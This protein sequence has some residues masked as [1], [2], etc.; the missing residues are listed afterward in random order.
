M[1]P[2]RLVYLDHSASTPVDERVMAAMQ[3][4]FSDGYGNSSSVHGFGRQAERA[5]EDARETVARVL[6]CRPREIVFNSGGTE[7]DNQAIRGAAWMMRHAGHGDH[8]LSSPTEHSAV[9]QTL[10]QLT[11]IQGFRSNMLPVD[12]HGRCS[13]T[14]FEAACLPQSILASIMLANNETGSLQPVR[15]LAGAAHDR[16]I[17]FHSDAVQAAGQM[18]LDVCS[19]GVDMLNISAHKF[20][21]PKGVGA[22]Y[23]RDGLE[24]LPGQTGGGHEA[25]RRAGTH[26][27]P[28][29]VGLARALE[30]AEAERE[31]RVA[32]FSH[33]RDLLIDRILSTVPDAVLSGHPLERLPGHAS[34]VFEGLDSSMLLMHLDVNGVAAS[35]GSACNTGNP[36]P[37]EVLLAMGF[38]EQAAIG[39]LRLSVGLG[40]TEAD[41]EYAA[42]VLTSAV[43]RLRGLAVTG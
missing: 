19:L 42:S 4:W 38:S 29:I 5:I 27:T 14:D 2:K 3:P 37:S 31:Q 8:L 35:G 34:F 43:E 23:V 22:L 10:Q 20:Y 21:G 7:G 28:L 41:V 16:G 13:V 18:A 40:T 6:N 1:Q 25:G 26:N 33:L 24:L 9:S 11:E 32:H 17:L 12:R 36:E 39:G 15:Q 30:L